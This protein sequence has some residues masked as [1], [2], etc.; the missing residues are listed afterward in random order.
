MA[1]VNMLVHI[2]RRDPGRAA[3]DKWPLAFAKP[4]DLLDGMI[5]KVLQIVQDQTYQIWYTNLGYISPSMGLLANGDELPALRKALHGVGIPVIYLPKT[6]LHSVQSRHVVERLSPTSL[7]IHLERKGHKVREVQEDAKQVLLEYIL[8]DPS[9]CK[10]GAIELF[11]FEDGT[12][13]SIDECVAFVHR[14][15]D[16]KALF[17]RDRSR[18]IDL[19]K[20]SKNTLQVLRDG[21]LHSSLHANLQKRSSNGLKSYCMSTYFKGFDMNQEFVCLDEDMKVF[22]FKVWD[23]IIARGYSLAEKDL[24]CLWL[25]PVSN[26]QYRKLKPQHLSSGTIFAPPG[27]IGDFLRKMATID[28]V[29]KKPIV[30][31]DSLSS[32]VLKLFTDASAKDSSMLVKNGEVLA[33]FCL[34]LNNIPEVLERALDADKLRL[35]KLLV[36][37]RPLSCD[38]R[39]VSFALGKLKIFQ[40]MKWTSENDLEPSLCW[41]SLDGYSKVIG[42]R[43]NVPVP[44]KT[45]AIFLD[46]RSE[47]TSRFL[48]EFRLAACPSTIDLLKEFTI[49][50]WEAGRFEGLSMPC[51]EH[52]ARLFLSNFYNFEKHTKERVASLAFIPT[53]RIDGNAVSKFATAAQLIDSSDILLRCLYF[54]DEEV[55][56]AKWA[57]GEFRG[58][59]IDCGLQNSITEDLVKGRLRCFANR[60]FDTE[61]TWKRARKLLQSKVDWLSGAD[62]EPSATIRELEWLP[63]TNYHGKKVLASASQC[64]GLEDQ[65][66]V[67]LVRS[68]VKFDIM[69]DW[70]Q[71]LGWDEVIPSTTLLAQLKDGI[72]KEDREIVNAVLKYIQVKDQ[73][74]I[75]S[76]KLINLRCVM[77]QAGRFVNHQTVFRTGCERLE[78]YLHNVDNSFW[79]NNSLLL[80]R[81]EIKEKPGLEDLLRVQRELQRK[82]EFKEGATLDERDA[83]VAIEIIKLAAV[84][85]REQL[86]TLMVVTTLGSL[87]TLEEATYNDLGPFGNAQGITHFTHPDIPHAVAAKLRIEPLSERVKK[88]ELELGDEDDEDEFDQREAVATGIADTLERYPVEATF[89]EYLANADDA[90]ANE[91]SWLLDSREHPRVSLVAPGLSAY[92]GPALLVHNDGTFQ[93]KDFD[94]FKDVGRGSKREDSTTIGKFG[95]GSQTMYHWT[96]VPMLLSGGYLVI[97]E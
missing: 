90:K 23:W 38:L 3:F 70:R 20:L 89:K 15:E 54:D 72:E 43:S 47:I 1:W 69:A 5:Q 10:Y 19:A 30:L 84:F 7:C 57:I 60:H 28:A 68:L 96:D 25:V 11:P 17:D 29:P 8:S 22:V 40:E 77:T 62:T 87:C 33:D 73:G 61:K 41:T 65:L 50:N 4:G 31:P 42:L 71:R 24:S 21:L 92:Q 58:V 44:A 37:R 75:L 81:L 91:I 95:R 55:C 12:Y 48:T 13:K 67:G 64:R 49:I 53:C 74:E 39:A 36:S 26:G 94:G 66:L 16:E 93:G 14:D 80:S 56:P 35:H 18:S 78:P 52:I 45:E 88:G 51:R 79:K 86:S 34:W 9:F 85:D 82:T 32:R 76:Q 63:A 83:G 2:A 27:E 6:L 46:A 97:L 59:L